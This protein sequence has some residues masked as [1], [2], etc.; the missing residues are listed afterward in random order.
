MLFTVLFTPG[1]RAWG[2]DANPSNPRFEQLEQ[3]FESRILPL[4]QSHCVT[5]HGTETSEA[6]LDLSSFRRLKDVSQSHRLWKTILD[7][8]EA[9][10]MPPAEAAEVF[11]LEDSER[12]TITRW[13]R[14]IRK[15]D[16]ERHA[17]DPGV[18]LAPRLSNA[19]YDY[20]IRDLTGVDIQPTS[21]F[22]ID[23]ANEAGFDNSGESL[24]MSPAL[25]QKYLEATRTI[26]DHLVLTPDGFH[27]APH[28]VSVDT[29]R[30]KY[31]V[32]RIVDFY[33]RQPTDYSDYFFAAWRYRHR[34]A[35]G[36][37]NAKLA[38]IANQEKVSEKYLR[39]V[40]EAFDQGNG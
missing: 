33:R 6:E 2:E 7:R 1:L 13:I 30:D 26:V 38:D 37:P 28:S 19:Q 24:S 21:T 32:K 39:L 25:I 18:V 5:C 34:V 11:V 14:S 27:F 4:L 29:D 16:A 12:S 40:W 9:K 35:F 15:A 3:E 36:N 8:L 20:S 23:P 31:C 10:E 17:G 22:P